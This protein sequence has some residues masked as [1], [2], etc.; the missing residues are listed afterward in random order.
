[1]R[2]PYTEEV[3]GDRPDP[4]SSCASSVLAV[5]NAVNLAVACLNWLHL[6]RPSTAPPEIRG[7]GLLTGCQ[8]GAVQ[9]LEKSLRDVVLHEAVDAAAMGRVAAKVENLE[10]L[11]SELSRKAAVVAKSM[12]AYTKQSSRTEPLFDPGE[13]EYASHLTSHSAKHMTAKPIIAERISFGPAPKF[14][15]VPYMDPLTRERYLYPLQH[16]LAEDEAPEE[17]PRARFLASKAEKTKFLH[18]LGESGRLRLVPVA[19]ARKRCLNGAFAVP[20]DLTRDRFILDARGPNLLEE[21]LTRWTQSM[22]LAA[23]LV[24]V[25]LKPYEVLLLSGTDLRDYYFNFVI[26]EERIVRNCLAGAVDESFVRAYC[27][28]EVFQKRRGPYRASL[29][30]LA[31][32]DINS[33]EF[34]QLA[35]L[36]LALSS[37]AVAP[38]ELLTLRSK[39]SASAIAGGIVI[40]DLVVMEKI[41]RE[42]VAAMVPGTSR[43]A[44]RLGK[45]E[46]AYETAGLEQSKPKTFKEK[47][48]ATVWGALVD[49][50]KGVVRPVPERLIPV[51][52]L[53]VEVIRAGVATRHI[54]SVIS[55]FFV[56]VFQFRRRFMAL[57]EEVFKAPAWMGDH[58]MFEIWPALAA[59]L[60]SLVILAPLVQSNLRASFCTELA[61]TDAS[62]EWEAEVVTDLSEPLVEELSRHTLHKSVWTRL[63]HPEAAIRRARGDLSVEE[64]LPGDETLKGNRLWQTLFRCLPFEVKWRQRIRR[65]RH[66]NVHELRAIIRSENRRAQARPHSKLLTGADSQV[67]LGAVIKGR[68]ASSKLNGVLRQSL[69]MHIS[70][71]TYG[72]YMYVASGD[73]P[74]DDPTRSVPLRGPVEEKPAWLRAAMLGDFTSFDT[75]LEQCNLDPISLLGLPPLDSICPTLSPT[76][77]FRSRKDKRREWVKSLRGRHASGTGHPAEVFAREILGKTAP[78]REDVCLLLG[79]LP[80]TEVLDKSGAGLDSK[81]FSFGVHPGHGDIVLRRATRDFP[82]TCQAVSAF[83][84]RSAPDCD[85][86]TVEMIENTHVKARRIREAE[87]GCLGICLSLAEGEQ[88]ELWTEDQSGSE[89]RPVGGR[90]VPGRVW[91]LGR[92]VTKF[93]PK[94][95]HAIESNRGQGRVLVAYRLRQS[96]PLLGS[97]R[98]I[99]ASLNIDAEVSSTVSSWRGPP[100]LDGPP[101]DGDED[102]FR[103]DRPASSSFMQNIFPSI[104]GTISL[105]PKPTH[106]SVATDRLPQHVVQSLNSFRQSQFVLPP[107]SKTPL[108]ELLRQPGFLDVYSGSRGV[109]RATAKLSQCWVLCVDLDHGADEDLLS[110]ALQERLLFLVAHGAFRGV[111]GGPICSSFSRAVRPPVRSKIFPE[112]LPEVRGSMR[113][114]VEQ[115]NQHADFTAT[116]AELGIRKGIF[117]WFENPHGSYLWR[118]ARWKDL[119]DK[120]GPSSYAVIDYCQL[121]CAWRKRTRLFAPGPL[122]GQRLLCQGRRL[123]QQLSGHSALHCKQW[124]KVAEPYPAA[125]NRILASF[126]AQAVVPSAQ[127]L[128]L[129]LAACAK[130]GCR[131]IGDAKNPGPQRPASLEEVSLVTPA[132]A[133]LQ[134][135]VVREFREWLG[136][137]LSAP[138]CRSVE[139]CAMAFVL[140]LRAYGNWLYQHSEPMYKYRHLLAFF[141]KR[142]MQLRPFLPTAW[143]LLTRWE[144]VQPVRH[145]SPMPL[146]IFQAMMALAM[147]KGWIHW[148]VIAGLAFYGAARTGETLR[149]RRED[150]L[151]PSDSLATLDVGCYLAILSP[152][153][154]Y[155][156]KGR[157]QHIAVKDLRF[158]AFLERVM[159][160]APG[161]VMLYRGSPAAFRRRWDSLLADLEVPPSL[162]LTPGSLR[163]GGAV[164]LYKS[165]LSIADLMWRMRLKTITSLESYL[166]EMAAH[167]VLPKLPASGRRLVT[168]ASALYSHVLEVAG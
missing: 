127:R 143:D 134:D 151:L 42:A 124:T 44:V 136:S 140:V 139:S 67:A 165:G 157:V 163:A 155:R 96:T 69:P 15:P 106:T 158:V 149:A 135:R 90:S 81:I 153:T 18:R 164:H 152:K 109:A 71:D 37:G 99:L 130:C 24:H 95:W 8:K 148:C 54:L 131:C 118:T 112:G 9:R 61:A 33:V 59:E 1:M 125:L 154:A 162:H 115:G 160:S 103:S 168:A 121:G 2:L 4:S 167:A 68:S 156:G 28:H 74:S 39:P 14:D 141:Q 5:H 65:R 19:L 85:F 3:H 29:G 80:S 147:L 97:D 126:L 128:R 38:T 104:R 40:D 62:D 70:L 41:D 105:E 133:K 10:Q 111:G 89:E 57:L 132:T 142:S 11:I 108:E 113:T 35:H 78:S 116:L 50:D 20:K 75:F 76:Q 114:K 46:K 123:H 22:A 32:G 72:L 60:W 55:G 45:V 120:L 146:A 56:A 64:E 150:L 145:R 93:Y 137:E 6:G 110:P 21:G 129:D 7:V 31:M 144:R 16:S 138:A 23:S 58:V 82:L 25:S 13:V 91:R 83:V 47:L 88:G 36:S 34:G 27:G 52:S 87:I 107:G 73:N 98:A 84:R 30:S 26:S 102:S 49:G 17:P 63:L 161:E 43:G 117:V 101:A 100:G 77:D 94:N 66:I 166:Q 122:G 92:T 53:T 86:N 159:G 48:R 51:I 79:L 119:I 12:T